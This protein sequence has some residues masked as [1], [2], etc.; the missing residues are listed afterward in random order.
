[1]KYKV[2]DNIEKYKEL[3]SFSLR[4]TAKKLKIN[5]NIVSQFVNHE[6]CTARVDVICNIANC[7]NVKIDDLLFTNLYKN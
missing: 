2:A 4:E 3:N 5:H 7:L 1:M 6:R